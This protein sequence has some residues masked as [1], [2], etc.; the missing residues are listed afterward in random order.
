MSLSRTY[1][2]LHAMRFRAKSTRFTVNPLWEMIY[3]Q[4]E[5]AS[6]FSIFIAYHCIPLHTIA[7]HCMPLHSLQVTTR[8]EAVNYFCTEGV[9]I[10]KPCRFLGPHRPSGMIFP[11]TLRSR[12]RPA[13]PLPFRAA[14]TAS[15][16]PYKTRKPYSIFRSHATVLITFVC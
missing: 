13:A 2:L 11:S 5:G 6:D 10:I 1:D 4:R 7:Y 16:V 9:R 3:K 8:A 15:P 14:L 12:F